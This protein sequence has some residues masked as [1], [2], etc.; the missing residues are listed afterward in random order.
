MRESGAKGRRVREGKVVVVEGGSC[1]KDL[2]FVG[3]KDVLSI[4][5]FA[6]ALFAIALFA[7]AFCSEASVQTTELIETK[8]TQK[9]FENYLIFFFILIHYYLFIFCIIQ[10]YSEIAQISVATYK[11]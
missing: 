9:S 11:N 3:R 7:V 1:E 6:I 5:L 2:R 8:T 10:C 4:A